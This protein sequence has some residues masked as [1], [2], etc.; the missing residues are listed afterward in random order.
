MSESNVHALDLSSEFLFMIMNLRLGAFA[1][2]CQKY[3]NWNPKAK[4]IWA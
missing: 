4:K 2:F 1:R 3:Q